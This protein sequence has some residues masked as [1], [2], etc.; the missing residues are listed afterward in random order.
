MEHLNI[1]WIGYVEIY[2]SRRSSL[3]NMGRD[4][5]LK[6]LVVCRGPCTLCT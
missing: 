6:T 4:R 5:P 1:N 2:G 3:I